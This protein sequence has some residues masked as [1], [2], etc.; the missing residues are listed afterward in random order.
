[1]AFQTVSAVH[2]DDGYANL[3]LPKL[4][5]EHGLRGL[6]AAFATELAYGT[7]RMGGSLDAVIASAADRAVDRI[8]PP[9]RDALRLGAYQLLHMRVPAHAATSTTVDLV[10]TVAPG[11]IGFANAVLRRIGRQ[12]WPTWLGELG[13]DDLGLRYAHPPWVVR[14]FTD[15][16][17]RKGELEALLEAD[18]TP[19]PVHLCARPGRI[20][21][22]ELADQTGG[23]VGPYGAYAVHLSEGSPGDHAAVKRGLAHVQDEGS[24]LVASALADAPIDGPDS[25]WLDLCAGPGGKA[26]L[27]GSLAALRDARVTAVEVAPHRAALVEHSVRGLPVEVVCEDGRSFESDSGDGGPFDRVLVDAPCTGLGAL[28][29]RPE[30]RWR[31]QP[32]DLPPLTRLQRELLRS[33]LR[34]VRPGGLVAYV[35]CSPHVN[36]TRM[37]VNETIRRFDGKVEQLDARPLLANVTNSGDGPAAQLWPHRHGTDAMFL[38]LLK[39]F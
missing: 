24:Q 28:R 18:N 5:V 20:T 39:R 10:R 16:L 1:V 3:V 9:T 35:T 38:A 26:A 12:D 33:A 29:R 11:A 2:R 17:D 27:L 15:A 7:L 37:T 31:R 21:A 22:A 13:P 4:I 14:A 32:N 34:L 6:D 8:D 25:R 36:E 30:A 23:T 19:A